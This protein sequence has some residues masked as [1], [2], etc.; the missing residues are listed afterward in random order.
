MRHPI[1]LNIG[2]E[3]FSHEEKQYVLRSFEVDQLAGLG[4]LALTS[5]AKVEYLVVDPRF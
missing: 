1:G 2:D 3:D 4:V 5:T